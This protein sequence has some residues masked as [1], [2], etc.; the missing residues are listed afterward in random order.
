LHA[1]LSEIGFVKTVVLVDRVD[2]PSLVNGQPDRM[3]KIIWPLLNNKFLQ[4]EGM[5]LKLLLPI[6]LGHLLKKE[7]AEFYQQARLDKQNMIERLSWS[8][9]SLYDI[10]TQRLLGCVD[11]ES[12]V[13]KMTD[14][15]EEG[16]TAAELSEALGQMMHPRDAFKFLYRV[17]QE[18]CQ[19]STDGDGQWKI[20]KLALDHVRKQEAQRM[21]DFHAGYGP[22]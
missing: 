22:G 4:Q 14:L 7:D 16:V 6:E 10:C 17:V 2:E 5:G 12:P 1:I 9:S 21:H 18:H 20:P 11:T 13:K 15:F 8:G 19:G 3:R